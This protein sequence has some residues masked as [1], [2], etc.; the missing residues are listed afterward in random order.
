MPPAAG[1]VRARPCEKHPNFLDRNS[2]GR[3][4]GH[5]MALPELWS[6]QYRPQGSAPLQLP[7]PSRLSL[8][9]SALHRFALVKLASLT[10]GPL[11][12]GQ[13]AFFPRPQSLVLD[14]TRKVLEELVQTWF[15]LEIIGERAKLDA[16]AAEN[17]CATRMVRFRTITAEAIFYFP[18]KLKLAYFPIHSSRRQLSQRKLHPSP[19]RINP[20]RPHAHAITVLPH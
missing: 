7:R 19:H 1:Q 5:R 13:F 14:S 20:L 10:I 12:P 4:L 11:Q 17:R 9:K 16:S 8:P 15:E 18:S 6:R 3:R 2:P